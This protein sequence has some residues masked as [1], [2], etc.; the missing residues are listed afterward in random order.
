MQKLRSQPLKEA[1]DHLCTLNVRASE[2]EYERQVLLQ[3][4]QRVVWLTSCGIEKVSLFGIL[5]G[6][7]PP[8]NFAIEILSATHFDSAVELGI[9]KNLIKN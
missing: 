2:T 8:E 5:F 9:E 6:S 3:K 4:R 1:A 7:P